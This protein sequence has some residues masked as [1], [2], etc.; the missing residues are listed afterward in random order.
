MIE[1]IREQLESASGPLR[2]RLQPLID[3]VS[4]VLRR[5][6][7][8]TTQ[9]Q[10]LVGGIAF[11]LVALLVTLLLTVLSPRKRRVLRRRRVVPTRTDA[12]ATDSTAED[13]LAANADAAIGSPLAPAVD[14]STPPWR[15]T[16]ERLLLSA[17]GMALLALL[18][19][20]VTYGVTNSTAYCTFR[21]HQDL[22]EIP[23]APSTAPLTATGLSATAVETTTAEPAYHEDCGGCHRSGVVTD[24]MD[25][26]RMVFVSFTGSGETSLS[27]VVPSSNCLRC[28]R[29]I[30]RDVVTGSG[31][32]V[33][34]SHKEPY[35][36]GMACDYCH[37]RTGHDGTRSPQM[38]SCSECHDGKQASV[39]CST[40]HTSSPSDQSTRNEPQGSESRRIYRAVPIDDNRCYDCHRPAACDSCHGVRVPHTPEFY[41]GRHAYYAAWDRKDVCYVCHEVESCQD[42]HQSFAAGSNHYAS[43]E[44]DH[45]RS[46]P[47]ARCSCHDRRSPS[48]TEP[49]CTVC[50]WTR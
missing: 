23:E 14:E 40:C 34:M 30:L 29:S 33:R 13:G 5:D 48:R 46:S 12:E 20:A 35:E 4:A 38:S 26:G 49:F 15:R 19:F 24:V 17:P 31:S 28:H 36:A 16:A 27:A 25:R 45:V 50:H 44:Q 37:A 1:Q 21:C 8:I 32:N 41:A 18:L 11:L 6:P 9:Q 47:T 3:L 2:E 22:V 43:W 10:I 7:S 39:E 42:C